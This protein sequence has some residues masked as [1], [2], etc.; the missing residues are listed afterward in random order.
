M[1]FFIKKHSFNEFLYCEIQS[2]TI[3]YVYFIY[4][5]SVCNSHR[6]G[7]RLSTTYI[8]HIMYI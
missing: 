8:D 4:T 3:I 7:P 5:K 6:N 2:Y 1:Q